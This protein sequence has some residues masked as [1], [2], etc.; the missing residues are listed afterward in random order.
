MRLVSFYKKPC[1]CLLTSLLDFQELENQELEHYKQV[2]EEI[3]N[4]DN[5]AITLPLKEQ[6]HPLCVAADNGQFFNL[7]EL[8][9]EYRLC[10]AQKQKSRA[11]IFQ[12]DFRPHFRNMLVQCGESNFKGN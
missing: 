11:T 5:T 6:Q 4:D 9:N 7:C 3:C 1:F 12:Y 8:M 2:V 10:K